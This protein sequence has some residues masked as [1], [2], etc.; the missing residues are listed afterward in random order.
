M[1]VA[2]F[3]AAKIS[4][5]PQTYLQ[6]V[7]SAKADDWKAA[8]KTELGKME[9]YSV[10]EVVN[11]EASMRVIG[12]KW[13]YSV[14]LDGE[15]GEIRLYKARWVAKGYYQI[16]GVDFGELW[17]GVARKDT[18]RFLLAMVNH[19]DLECDQVDDIHRGVS[20]R[21]T[22][23]RNL[24]GPS[25][26]F[27]YPSRQGHPSPEIPLR[28][29][30]APRCFNNA[31]DKWLKEQGF[32]P[33][34]ADSCLYVRWSEGNIIL[35][36]VHVDDQLIASNSRPALDAFKAELH[37]KLL[38]SGQ[39]LPRFQRPSG[40]GESEAIHLARALPRNSA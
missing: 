21:R 17:A 8:M 23:G 30:Q 16:E 4:A 33:T 39:L 7:H 9:K 5:L 10:W 36:S 12:A 14:K 24:H 26:R 35:L 29:K 27:G 11:R 32:I 34:R 40:S 6:A 13:V 28:L 3:H 25:T 18:I 22:R 31:F 19:F 20:Q 37:A 2:F 15:T 38:R 1:A